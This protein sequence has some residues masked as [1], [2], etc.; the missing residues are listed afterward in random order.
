M[1]ASY[2]EITE[3]EQASG[4]LTNQSLGNIRDSFE[5]KGFAVVGG[6]VSLQSCE[7]LSQAIVE[8]V[9][10]IRAREQ[11]TRHEKHTGIGHLQLGLRRYAPYVKPD[12]V[13]NAL[14]EHIVSSLLGAGAW[15]GFYNGNVNCPGSGY[16]PLHFDRPYSWKTQ[17]QAIAAGKSWP[18]PTTTLSCSLALSDITEATG[19]TEIYPGSQ[20][21][22]VVASWKTGE[23]PENHPDLI[24]QWGPARRMTIP[25]GGIC[26]RDPRMWHRGVPNLS[27]LAR[28]MIAL[29]YHS[30]L[31][32]H[33]RGLVVANMTDH[34]LG[35]CEEDPSLRVLDNGE[36]GDG[37][38]IFDD[39][40]RSA[41]ESVNRHGVD[42]NV[43]FVTDPYRVNHFLDAHALGGARV[44]TSDHITPYLPG[45][46]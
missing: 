27:E 9:A 31:A 34:D 6:L 40:G 2:F 3:Q 36:L 10:L 33:W 43:R 15:L 44:V 8:D 12:L 28:P 20:L 22:T 17:Q 45:E 19:A 30:G 35:R 13:A 1:A 29:T 25:A 18:P 21:E 5:T 38:L 32:K 42:R 39:S 16:Q 46:T 41:F 37:R 4:A 24:E 14:I 23:R 7:H 11:P 26:F